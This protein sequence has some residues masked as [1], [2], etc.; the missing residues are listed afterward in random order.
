[1]KKKQ[2]AEAIAVKQRRAVG[3]ISLFG[4]KEDESDTGDDMNPDQANDKY[5]LQL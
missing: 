2:E 4:K 3:E 1:M 5:S